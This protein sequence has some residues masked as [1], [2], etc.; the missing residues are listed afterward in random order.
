M[1]LY[2]AASS[3]YS[4]IA[5][6]A[7]HEAGVNFENHV[8]DIHFAKQQLSPWY[9]AINPN[10]TVPTLVD[11][12]EIFSDS[13][14]ILRFA[15]TQAGLNWL[16]A[17]HSKQAEIESTVNAFYAIQ[18]E[19]ITFGKL[20]IKYPPLHVM[21]PKLL[22]KIIKKLNDQLSTCSDP[23]AVKAKIAI[24]EGRLAFFTE[25][26]LSEKIDIEREHIARFLHMLPKPASQ[27]LLYGDQISSADVECGVLL[28]RLAMIDEQALLKPFPDLEAWFARLQTRPAFVKSDIW[29]KFHLL[30]ALRR[31]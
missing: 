7:L 20:M 31:R 21:F 14:D 9:R 26:N 23:D 12:Q 30:R 15:A 16:D 3:Y 18:I 1:V 29:L 27:S 6:L 24:N 11:G 2:H 13:H 25:G 8:I 28:G 17:D 4:M 10:M 22:G 5:R 19:N